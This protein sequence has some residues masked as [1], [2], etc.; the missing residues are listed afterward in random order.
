MNQYVNQY[1]KTAV[2]TAS[3]EQ[4]LLM[5]YDGAIKFLHKA[6]LAFETNDIE[7]IHN[8]ITRAERIITEFQSTLDMENGGRFAQELYSLYEYLNNRLFM[9]NMKKRTDYID[10]VLKHLT[11]LRDTWREAI[12][13]FKA[14]GHTMAELESMA[15]NEP[16]EEEIPR[17]ENDIEI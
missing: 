6:K 4:I 10:E 11:E 7:Q 1:K 2:N 14:E 8:N 3:K 15:E 16:A 9:A 17:L 12:M 13:K 5:L